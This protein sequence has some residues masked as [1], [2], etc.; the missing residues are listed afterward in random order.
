[1]KTITIIT[2]QVSDGALTA[3]LPTKAVASVTV[4][5]I[6]ARDRAFAPTGS[7]RALCNP[8]RFRAAYRIDV[9]VE[10][11]AV[12]TVFDAVSFAYGAGLFSDAEMWV[13]E[14]LVALSA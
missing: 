2:E 6:S 3:V 1:M 14:P 4:R 12:E 7:Y 8:N 13:N 5:R 10:E 9:M 11:A